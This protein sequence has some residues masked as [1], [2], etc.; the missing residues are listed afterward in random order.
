MVSKL[1]KLRFLQIIL[2][3]IWF[4]TMVGQYSRITINMHAV[5]NWLPTPSRTFL[6]QIFIFKSA[7]RQ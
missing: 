2:K 4:L 1:Q 3:T 5:S 6:S 7:N